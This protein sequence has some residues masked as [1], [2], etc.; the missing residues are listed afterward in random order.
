M[1]R[2][3][4]CVFQFNRGFK[5]GYLVYGQSFLFSFSSQDQVTKK[6][7]FVFTLNFK[8]L[9]NLFWLY[10]I[11]FFLLL[12]VMLKCLI[13]LKIVLFYPLSQLIHDLRLRF[14]F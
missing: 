7:E 13:L 4:H 9:I 3:D 8:G 5:L 2:L 6:L 14:S 1:E 11:E 12:N 10:L